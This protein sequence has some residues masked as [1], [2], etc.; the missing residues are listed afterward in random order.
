MEEDRGGEAYVVCVD[1]W[2]ALQL[3]CFPMDSC[4]QGVGNAC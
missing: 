3:V 2:V 1:G 4:R